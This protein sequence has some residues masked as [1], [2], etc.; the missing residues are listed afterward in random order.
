[1]P[2]T[3]TTSPGTRRGH[4]PEMAAGTLATHKKTPSEPEEARS[5]SMRV[6]SCF[7]LLCGVPGRREAKRRSFASGIVAIGSR[8][9][10]PSRLLHVGGDMVST[11]LTTLT[12][13][14][15]RRCC[16]SF[17]L[18]GDICPMASHSSGTEDNPIGQRRLEPG[19]LNVDG[20]SSSGCHLTPQTSIRW[21][22]SGVTPS[23][24][25]W[26]TSLPTAFRTSNTPSSPL[27]PGQEARDACSRPSS[28]QPGSKCDVFHLIR[29][30][31]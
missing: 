23:M 16:V 26:R 5:F 7:S 10:V 9:S 13:F 29:K 21:R 24:G 18:C 6:A 4:D 20:S 19:L 14:E 31:Q 25:I 8:P 15:A 3:G 2:E 28:E 30:A 27:C 17:R 22:Q 1:L 12:T 11:G